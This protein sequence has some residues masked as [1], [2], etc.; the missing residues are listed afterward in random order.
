MVAPSHDHPPC[1]A[2]LPG[3]CRL[4]EGSRPADRRG[5][6]P[7]Q[8]AALRL[9][10]ARGPA[11][12]SCFLTGEE[13][14]RCSLQQHH[15]EALPP[16]RPPPPCSESRSWGRQG[17]LH[18]FTGNPCRAGSGS[19]QPRGRSSEARRPRGSVGDCPQV[20][21]VHPQPPAAGWA[22]GGR[23]CALMGRQTPSAPAG[24]LRPRALEAGVSSGRSPRFP[25][26]APGGLQL[27]PVAAFT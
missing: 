9:S 7:G 11:R 18:S 19:A 17:R 22:P 26:Q 21:P 16:P 6:S 27:T 5:P 10:Q 23:A 20:S 25:A 13:V 24:G 3:R 12:P 8:G 4:S 2:A 15:E 14:M 1:C